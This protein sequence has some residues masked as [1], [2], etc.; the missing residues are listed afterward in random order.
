[1]ISSITLQRPRHEAFRTTMVTNAS[2][3]IGP[4]GSA[5][6]AVGRNEVQSGHSRPLS[7]I[8]SKCKVENVIRLLPLRFPWGVSKE[9]YGH[10]NTN[11]AISLR[12]RLDE[13]RFNLYLDEYVLHEQA[14]GEHEWFA[15]RCFYERHWRWGRFDCRQISE[16]RY[17][18]LASQ[19]TN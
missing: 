13:T 16:H 11:E 6:I 5:R 2:S 8:I 4:S 10:G 9:H 7:T 1:M 18:L 19:P 12:R 15:H 3:Y 14:S 17:K